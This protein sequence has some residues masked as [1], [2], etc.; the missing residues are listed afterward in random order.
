MT[1][2]PSIEIEHEERDV[3]WEELVYGL[4]KGFPITATAKEIDDP[5]SENEDQQQGIT[6]TEYTVLNTY[7]VKDRKGR[8]YRL[9]KLYNPQR[10]CIWTGDWCPTY[11]KVGKHKDER[12]RLENKC[13]FS[14]PVKGEFLMPYKNYLEMFCKTT[15]CYF[16]TKNHFKKPLNC[17]RE[18]L[19]FT[20]ETET[21]KF[22]R[23]WIE[24]DI[25]LES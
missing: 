11:S 15:I 4:G 12:D 14:E 8:Q 10:K 21:M 9:V 22:F 3:R 1:N 13:D 16:D 17:Q 20:N 2:M 5:D 19:D 18:K 24:E 6:Q 23:I 7:K 25:D